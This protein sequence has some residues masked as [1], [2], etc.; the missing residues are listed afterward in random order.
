MT[1]P[2]SFQ[3]HRP[4]PVQVAVAAGDQPGR[5]GRPDE[6]ALR[7]EHLAGPERQP[8][9]DLDGPAH[10][11]PGRGV[12]GRA[13]GDGLGEVA[14]HRLRQP[15]QLG[16]AEPLRPGRPQQPPL[17]VAGDGRAHGQSVPRPRR[18]Q[19]RAERP[20][21]ARTSPARAPVTA[22]PTAGQAHHPAPP[23][24]PG[25]PAPLPATRCRDGQAGGH[26]GRA[27]AA[28]GVDGQV[29]G[30]LAGGRVDPQVAEPHAGGRQ[31]LHA[32]V[33]PQV[34]QELAGGR[35]ALLQG[36]PVGAGADR[37]G[38][39]A[40]RRSVSRYTSASIGSAGWWPRPRMRSGTHGLAVGMVRWIGV[41][42]PSA[43]AAGRGPAGVEAG[44]HEDRAARG[45]E[46]EHLGG[47]ERQP[48]AVLAWP[49]RRPPG[50]RP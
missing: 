21:R 5:P 16:R 47:V 42:S 4:G 30:Q 13:R 6:A 38:S 18:G 37:P 33:G 35:A 45:V 10:P 34:G 36:D 20:L 2:A 32:L 3:S 25:A 19:R 9:A 7:A 1:R 44:R 26:R 27:A 23:A 40:G 49:S 24:R 43:L 29:V 46:V 41:P 14:A 15:V 28:A 17:Q 39:R 48:E 31:P 11:Q 50:R 8:A 22:R 12:Q